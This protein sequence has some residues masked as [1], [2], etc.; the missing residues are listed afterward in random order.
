MKHLARIVCLAVMIALAAWP[1]GKKHKHDQPEEQ[2][3]ELP[4]ELPAA[5]VAD[6]S[7]LVFQVSP[8]YGRG[9]LTQQVREAL[10]SL[11]RSDQ[12]IVKLR[13]FVAGTGDS[14]RVQALVSEVCTEKR[15]PLPALSVVQVGALPREGAQVVLES[16]AQDRKPVN[17]H[18]VAFVSAQSA[19]V[20]QP[21]RPLRPLADQVVERLGTALDAAKVQPGDVLRVTCFLTSLDEVEQVRSP[22]TARW[23]KAS[24][25]FVQPLRETRDSAVACEA[26]GRL[27]AAPRERAEFLALPGPPQLPPSS[28]AVAVGPGKLVFTGA[29]LAFGTAPADAALAFE[30]LGKKIEQTAARPYGP[31]AALQIYALTRSTG[32]LAQQDARRFFSQ[33]QPP[34][35][36]VLSFEALPSMDASFSADVIAVLPE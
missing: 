10:K 33:S 34:A 5:T 25:S 9:L 19:L 14:R 30:R 15:A 22:L 29:Q 6:A 31:V 16:V 28:A 13:A 26:V 27:S 23:A 1:W 2:A 21:L 35:L 20:G 36:T 12:A 11:L 4:K 32:D 18:G 3:L 17:P 7:Q 24:L 8:L